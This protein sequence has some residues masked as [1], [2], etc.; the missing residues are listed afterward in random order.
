MKDPKL[1]AVSVLSLSGKVQDNL[2]T[3][4]SW[5]KKLDEEGV[6][7]IL[8]PELNI[9]GYVKDP[10]KLSAVCLQREDVFE[11][12]T[13]LSKQTKAAFAVGF[14]EKVEQG[15]Y[16]A[17]YVFSKG[18]LIGKHRKTHLGSTEKGFL[19]KAMK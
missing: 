8:F 6:D 11:A 1:A 5:I 14:P 9:S 18:K 17:H 3:T 2:I 10:Q 13:Q 19:L 7:F 16:I 4:I 12:L 15:F